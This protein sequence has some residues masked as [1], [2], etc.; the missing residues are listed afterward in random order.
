MPLW[1]TWHGPNCL[2]VKRNK[3]SASIGRM[4]IFIQN[5]G[6]CLQGDIF[7]GLCVYSQKFGAW[8]CGLFQFGNP[9]HSDIDF[10]DFIPGRIVDDAG[11][12]QTEDALESADRILSGISENTV[13]GNGRE[14]RI[15]LGNPIELFLH[16]H[17]LGTG[18]ADGQIGSGPG[19]RDAADLFRCV[20]IHIGTVIIMQDF[21]GRVALVAEILGTPLG[22]PVRAAYPAA[23]TILGQNRL[24]YI[25]TGQEIRKIVSTIRE[26]LSK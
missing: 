25:W 12:R 16:L 8:R 3:N 22:Q 26:I 14:G 21:K 1:K 18:R 9:G 17:H 23:V 15:G 4:P 2:F 6:K 24:T 13:R 5:P 7:R 20:Y 10:T 11:L 19:R